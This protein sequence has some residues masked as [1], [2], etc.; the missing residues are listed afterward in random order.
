M[1][2][3]LANGPIVDVCVIGSANCDLVARV[4]RLPAAGETVLGSTFTEH[5]GGKGLN[6]AVAAARAGAVTAFVAAVGD[7]HAGRHLRDVAA[8]EGI[9]VRDVVSVA[10]PTGRA[11]IAV[12]ARGENQI[13][14]VPGANARLAPSSE[15]PLCRVALA[16]LEIPVDTVTAAFRAARLDGATTVLNP[17]PA[18][19]L[20]EDLLDQ[21]D[22]VVPNEHEIDLLGGA[23]ELRRRGVGSVVVTLGSEGVLI[24]DDAGERHI[25]AH[26]VE[27]VDS[28]GAGDAFCGT[29]AA[30]LAAGDDLDTAVRVASA[31]G[32]LATTRE[33]AVPSLPRASEVEA[34]LNVAR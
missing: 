10:A 5:P 16:Q 3:N 33:G 30:R 21:C 23:A 13:V 12:D 27:T 14:V 24:V 32:A 17:A 1:E 31:A 28:T 25:A 26:R 29:L 2:H 20:P 9:D 34:F 19:H 8:G 15:I 22:V 7:D 6:Q 11:L 4:D 18:T